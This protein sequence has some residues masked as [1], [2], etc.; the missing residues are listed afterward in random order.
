MEPLRPRG[1]I[2]NHPNPSDLIPAPSP[3][4]IRSDRKP[5]QFGVDLIDFLIR[6]HPRLSALRTDHQIT[7]LTDRPIHK[8]S[9][10]T[11]STTSPWEPASLCLSSS[12]DSTKLWFNRRRSPENA[13]GVQTMPNVACCQQSVFAQVR[14]I[15]FQGLFLVDTELGFPISITRSPDYRLFRSR[16]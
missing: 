5:S 8:L 13:I 16:R 10:S 7:R 1:F 6:D 14:G 15:L 12:A 11:T 9:K 4:F 2:P 3:A